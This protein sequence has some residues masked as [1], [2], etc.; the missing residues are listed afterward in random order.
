MNGT[1]YQAAENLQRAIHAPPGAVNTLVQANGKPQFIRVLVDPSYW[2]LVESVPSTFD[3]Y[4]VVVE[5]R[6]ASTAGGRILDF[7]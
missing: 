2:L 5:K 3:G 6:Q 1:V 7:R 4:L